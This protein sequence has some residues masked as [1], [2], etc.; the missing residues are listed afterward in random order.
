MSLSTLTPPCRAEPMALHLIPDD[1]APH[2]PTLECG[3]DPYPKMV[4]GDDG[5]FRQ[6]F[7]HNEIEGGDVDGWSE[8][9]RT[10]QG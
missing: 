7:A 10:G 8:R 3:C 1:G 4:V 2:A 6:A 5:L 9:R